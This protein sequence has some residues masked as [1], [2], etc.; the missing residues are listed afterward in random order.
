MQGVTLYL[1]FFIPH[2]GCGTWGKGNQILLTVTGS[3]HTSQEYRTYWPAACEPPPKSGGYSQVEVDSC[4]DPSLV[5]TLQMQQAFSGGQEL[6]P[7]WERPVESSGDE[8]AA[9]YIQPPTLPPMAGIRNW[10]T[11]TN[12]K[13]PR[14]N[15]HSAHVCKHEIIWIRHAPYKELALRWK[16]RQHTPVTLSLHTFPSCQTCANNCYHSNTHYHS[17]NHYHSNKVRTV[18]CSGLQF[19]AFTWCYHGSQP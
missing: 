7:P 5:G 14:V 19:M 11:K 18:W 16:T 12:V 4:E 9:H 17:T 15:F 8:L 1:H 2:T 13:E 6:S 3:Y 10:W